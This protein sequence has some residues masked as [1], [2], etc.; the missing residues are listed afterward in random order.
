MVVL[1]HLGSNT[2]I[3]TLCHFLE[4]LKFDDLGIDYFF[5]LSVFII[6]YI[7]FDDI[8]Y[9]KNRNLYIKKILIIIYPI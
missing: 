6:T 5:V 4:F 1:F 3:I 2:M 8:V 9:K 7:Y